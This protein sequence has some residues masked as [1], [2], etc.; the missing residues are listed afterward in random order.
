MQ[1]IESCGGNYLHWGCW[2]CGF[3][4]S[5]QLCC[6]QIFWVVDESVE[7]HIRFWA[8]TEI[9]EMS[10]GPLLQQR[11]VSGSQS[12]A[13]YQVKTPYGTLGIRG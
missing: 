12:K 5:R 2:R 1:Q 10:H 3:E 4:I 7:P 9:S 13:S 6:R 11:F 8:H